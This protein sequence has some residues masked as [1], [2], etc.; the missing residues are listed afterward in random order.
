MAEIE[1]VSPASKGGR[2]RQKKRSTRVDMT[3]MVDV[4]FLLL[5][6]FILTTTMASPQAM[7]VNK[8]P[9]DGDAKPVAES[10]ILTFVLDGGDQVHYWQGSTNPVVR[11]VPL[12]AEE[13]RAV[14]HAH[15]TRF[16]QRCQT[17]SNAPGCWDPIFVIKP[18]RGSRF[19]NF[20]DM[21]DEMQ[22]SEVPKYAIADFLPEDS[23]LLADRLHP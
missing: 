13:I 18:Y 16:P 23:V 1:S 7:E 5:T 20:V 19:K 3:A 9:N 21:L 2:P 22:I 14:I 6:F 11:T 17:V 12:A 4:A 10:K 15:L 8:S